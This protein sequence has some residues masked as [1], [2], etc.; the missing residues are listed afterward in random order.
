MEAVYKKIADICQTGSLE[1]L[2]EMI[3]EY[4][5]IEK[6]LHEG[7][8]FSFAAFGGN[9][10]IVKYLFKECPENTQKQGARALCFAAGRGHLD[11]VKYLVETC[12]MDVNVDRGL[13]L[14]NASGYGDLGVVKYLIEK[15]GVAVCDEPLLYAAQKHHKDVVKYLLNQGA[16]F[17]DF[18]SIEPPKSE[19]YCLKAKEFCQKMAKEIKLEKAKDAEKLFQHNLKTLKEV[20]NIKKPV[21]RRP[22][23][24]FKNGKS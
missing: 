17:S 18:Q 21:R 23:K 5:E 15:C 16:S 24:N 1:Q 12:Q 9:L 4:P 6:D 20:K 19:A 8:A 3:K 14:C 11:V 13:P 10:D 7:L 22:R 2:Q